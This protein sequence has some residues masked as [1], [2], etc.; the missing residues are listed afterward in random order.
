MAKAINS[1]GYTATKNVNVWI[2]VIMW[3]LLCCLMLSE[4]DQ[5]DEEECLNTILKKA[6]HS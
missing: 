5:H 6:R 1:G 4:C 2:D 3:A